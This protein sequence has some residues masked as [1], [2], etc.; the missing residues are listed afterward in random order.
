M[1]KINSQLTDKEKIKIL[2]EITLEDLYPNKE[3]IPNVGDALRDNFNKID[4]FD[5]RWSSLITSRPL[6]FEDVDYL[7]CRDLVRNE[8]TEKEIDAYKKGK[9]RELYPTFESM[10]ILNLDYY[11]RI[12]SFCTMIFHKYIRI[13]ENQVTNQHLKKLPFFFEMTPTQIWCCALTNQSSTEWELNYAWNY[14]R[15]NI[16]KLHSVQ[17]NLLKLN[18]KYLYK[19]PLFAR[20]IEYRALICGT[21]GFM[22]TYYSDKTS[23]KKIA[24][25]CSKFTKSSTALDESQLDTIIN[26]IIEDKKSTENLYNSIKKCLDNIIKDYAIYCFGT[27]IFIFT[28][29]FKMKIIKDENGKISK[30]YLANNYECFIAEAQLAE[31]IKYQIEWARYK[32]PEEFSYD[33]DI[34]INLL[35]TMLVEDFKNIKCIKKMEDFKTYTEVTFS[36]IFDRVYAYERF[37]YNDMITHEN[38][39]CFSKQNMAEFLVNRGYY[40]FGTI[41]DVDVLFLKELTRNTIIQHYVNYCIPIKQHLQDIILLNLKN[42][43][44]I[45]EVLLSGELPPEKLSTNIGYTILKGKSANQRDIMNSVKKVSEN[46]HNKNKHTYWSAITS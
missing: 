40:I 34:L 7:R 24:Q 25:V 1:D 38:K 37:W 4:G 30:Q 17:E 45:I 29:K 12:M 44:D 10:L 35:T 9:L 14:T 36:G 11:D 26:Y 18:Y 16:I 43:N 13:S 28:N 33:K 6:L 5:Y 15:K 39:Y 3:Y 19:N 31:T 22:T 21:Q 2:K 23:S 32:T 8:V 27:E 46:L 20:F 41:H 42:N